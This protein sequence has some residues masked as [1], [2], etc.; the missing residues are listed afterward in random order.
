MGIYSFSSIFI[1]LQRFFDDIE[2][3]CIWNNNFLDFQEKKKKRYQT[4]LKSTNLEKLRE[5]KIIFIMINN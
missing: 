5:R 3:E 2:I 1:D 4:V